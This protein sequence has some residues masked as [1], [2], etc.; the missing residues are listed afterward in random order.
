MD[1]S[2]WRQIETILDQI[3]HLE[4]AERTRYIEKHVNDPALKKEI[5]AL[6]KAELNTPPFLDEGCDP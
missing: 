6:L 1:P 4:A 2:T 5:N 3:L